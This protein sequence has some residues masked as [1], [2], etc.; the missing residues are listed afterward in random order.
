MRRREGSGEKA[1]S[2]TTEVIVSR[3]L[4]RDEGW[5]RARSWR[6]VIKRV[7]VGGVGVVRGGRLER[8]RE[9]VGRE[10]AEVERERLALK[11]GNSIILLF[12]CSSR[13]GNS[14]DCNVGWLCRVGRCEGGA[15]VEVKIG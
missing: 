4:L 2:G 10:E 3:I 11:E 15:E 12:S 7:F 14:A 9:R 5:K 6:L 1:F 8:S 13:G